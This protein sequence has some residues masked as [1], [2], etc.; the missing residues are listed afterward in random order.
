MFSLCNPPV[1]LKAG[2]LRG[3]ENTCLTPS[4]EFT[5]PEAAVSDTVARFLRGWDASAG[6]EARPDTLLTYSQM[7]NVHDSLGTIGAVTL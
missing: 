7:E 6:A 2:E 3:N 4:V 1:P 5:L